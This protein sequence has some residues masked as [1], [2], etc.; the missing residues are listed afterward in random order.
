V[1]PV[2]NDSLDLLVAV[3]GAKGTAQHVMGVSEARF[4]AGPLTA[5]TDPAGARDRRHQVG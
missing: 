2:N 1:A 5:V 4:G 3:T